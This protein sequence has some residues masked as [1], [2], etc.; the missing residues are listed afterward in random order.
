M[1]L[2]HA[3]ASG[4]GGIRTTGDLVA[5]MQLRKMRLPQ[6]KRYVADRLHVGIL[7]L[8]DSTVMRELREELDIG[9]VT[10]VAT[11]AKGVEAKAHVAELLGIPIRSVERLRHKLDDYAP[12]TPAP[13]E[14]RDQHE[15]SAAEA[16]RA[17][18]DQEAADHRAGSD[19][20]YPEEEV[21]R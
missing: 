1:S 16:G 15:D 18:R 19:Q 7:D 2:C 8:T 3:L 17:W 10:G 6:A 12:S 11:A 13:A 21:T 4:M 5:R 9:T 14:R 20:R